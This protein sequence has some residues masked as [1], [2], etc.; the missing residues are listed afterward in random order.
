[1]AG[2]HEVAQRG[3]AAVHSPPRDV[4]SGPW[5][6]IA[7][8]VE[9]L[10]SSSTDPYFWDGRP[11]SK[12]KRATAVARRARSVGGPNGQAPVTLQGC[13]RTR[14]A[15]AYRQSVT[16]PARAVRDVR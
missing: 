3:K 1:Q 12:P 5:G 4:V 14:G 11:W 2:F 10:T 13:A 16:G 6:R 15:A 9:R 8:P 7:P